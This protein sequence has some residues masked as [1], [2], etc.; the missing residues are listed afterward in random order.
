MDGIDRCGVLERVDRSVDRLRFRSPPNPLIPT[1]PPPTHPP[2]PRSEEANAATAAD[3]S[4]TGGGS[5][6]GGNG[7]VDGSPL[8][9]LSRPEIVVNADGARATPTVVARRQGEEEG[10]G[11]AWEEWLVGVRESVRVCFG[12][13]GWVMLCVCGGGV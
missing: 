3:G 8:L 1:H 7:G 4:S 13:F 2:H 9:S 10:S 6:G 11:K 12:G 5:G